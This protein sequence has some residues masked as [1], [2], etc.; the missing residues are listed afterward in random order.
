MQWRLLIGIDCALVPF[1]AVSLLLARWPL[2]ACA[3]M[4]QERRLQ[5]HA[6]GG[7][8]APPLRGECRHLAASVNRHAQA[9]AAVDETARAANLGRGAGSSARLQKYAREYSL[10]VAE[11][12]TFYALLVLQRLNLALDSPECQQTVLG[13][14]YLSMPALRTYRHTPPASLSMVA[15]I[16]NFV[17]VSLLDSILLPLRPLSRPS[18]C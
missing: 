2:A 7:R 15:H 5:L 6:A 4:A 10:L 12:S 17:H 1:C 9:V 8:R 16:L 13:Q 11:S 18:S 14:I 3:A